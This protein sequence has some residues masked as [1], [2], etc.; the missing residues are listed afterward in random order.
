MR[1]DEVQ[2]SQTGTCRHG[3]AESTLARTSVESEQRVAFGT[4]TQ[5]RSCKYQP[6]RLND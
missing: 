5:L 2:A 6:P 1:S 4:A 3:M